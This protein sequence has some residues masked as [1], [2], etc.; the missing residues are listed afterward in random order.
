MLYSSILYDSGEEKPLDMEAGDI[1]AM[2]YKAIK[3]LIESGQLDLV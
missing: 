3:P 2:R 1:Y